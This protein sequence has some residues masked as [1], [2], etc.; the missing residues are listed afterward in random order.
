MTPRKPWSVRFTLTTKTL[1]TLAVFWGSFQTGGWGQSADKAAA[2]YSHY[3]QAQRYFAGRDLEKAQKEATLALQLIPQMAEAANLLGVIAAAGGRQTEAENYFARAVNLRPD[4]APSHYNLAMLYLGQNELIT[5]RQELETVVHL[6]PSHDGAHYAL[7][8]ILLKANKPSEAL[9]HFAKAHR[10]T[11]ENYEALVGLIECQVALRREKEAGKSFH[12]ITD[13]L[14]AR[15]PRLLQLGALLAGQGAYGMAIQ[16]FQKA[17]HADP[18]SYNANYNLALAFFL[19]GD[20]LK[21]EEVLKRLLVPHNVAEAHNLLGRVYEKKKQ[22]SEAATEYELAAAMD[23]SN[24]DFRFDYCLILIQHHA[25]EYGIKLLNQAVAD[26]PKSGRLWVALGGAYY[27]AGSYQHAFSALL[28]ATEVAPDLSQAYYYLG[29]DYNKLDEDLQKRIMEKLKSYLTFGPKDPWAHYFYG[30]GLFDNQ[31]R[32]NTKDFAEAEA[33]LKQA[34][35]LKNDLAEAHL[36]LG[37]LYSSE[38]KVADGLAE[39][40]LA[41]NADPAMPEAHYSLGLAYSKLGDKERAEKEFQLQQKLRAET[42]ER[43]IK[44]FVQIVPNLK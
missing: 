25:F 32:R 30:S 31:R 4:Y 37:L 6:D 18:E 34:I 40:R 9:P 14:D 8:Q 42:A 20:A 24:E 12:E 16:A 11:P 5:A 27:V 1:L 43:R 15:D 36:S 21:A 39:F 28:N 17:V 41:V 29:R 7:G 44:E 19:R 33:H 22:Y 10:I 26:F 38:G 35:R 2:A 23:P 13:L 3:Q